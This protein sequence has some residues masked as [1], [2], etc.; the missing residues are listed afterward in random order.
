MRIF[1]A[2]ATGVIGRQLV[3]LLRGA[4]HEV[5]GTT[6]KPERA[7]QLAAAGAEPVVVDVFDRDAIHEAVA[8]ARPDVIM[9]KLTDLAEQDFAANA[10]LRIEGTR[11]LVDAARAAGVERIVAQSIAWIYAPGDGPAAEDA[12]LDMDLPAIKGVMALEDAV[13]E[14][15]HWVVLRFGRLYGPGTWHAADGEHA[16]LARAGEFPAIKVRG[17]FVIPARAIDDMEAAALARGLV[18]ARTYTLSR[19]S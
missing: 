18:D 13:A 19:A 9:H 1:L 5:A 6:R 12:P 8:A 14:L 7:E 15:P 4:G 11:N 17:R 10:R 3:P 2:G 16:R